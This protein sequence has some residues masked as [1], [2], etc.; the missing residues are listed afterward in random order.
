MRNMDE[1]TWKTIST[2]TALGTAAGLAFGTYKVGT[3]A[4]GA[5]TIA[6]QAATTAIAGNNLALGSNT[7][8]LAANNAATVAGTLGG[9]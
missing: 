7:T 9:I 2:F 5:Y 6:K 1:S 8:A 3:A 4:V